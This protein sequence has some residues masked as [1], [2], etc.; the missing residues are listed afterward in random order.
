MVCSEDSAMVILV[1]SSMRR[2]V[3][4]EYRISAKL[5][6]RVYTWS[7]TSSGVDGFAARHSAKPLLII[8]TVPSS[9]VIL[10]TTSAWVEMDIDNI[11]VNSKNF[12]IVNL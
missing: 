6:S 9:R 5:S 10:A 3:P 2:T 4:I 12:F 11:E 7:P 1:F 8:L